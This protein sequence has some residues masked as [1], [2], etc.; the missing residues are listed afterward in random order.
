MGAAAGAMGPG[1]SLALGGVLTIGYV[2]AFLGSSNPVRRY[3]GARS[4][5]AQPASASPAG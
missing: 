3:T 1:V 2:G 4:A 5:E